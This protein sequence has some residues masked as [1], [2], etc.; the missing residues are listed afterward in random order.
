MASPLALPIGETAALDALRLDA[1]PLHGGD[2]DYDALVERVG[3]AT[4]VLLGEASHG[5]HEFYRERARITR[6]LIEELGFT[7]VA[8]EGDWP[9][10][11]RVSR[12]VQGAGDDADAEE[13][14]RGFQRF[15]TW[16]WRNAEV[17][18]FVG[19]LR[20][21]NEQVAP[22]RRSVGF[23]GLDL[24]SLGASMEAVVAYLEEVDPPAAARARSRYECLHP[25]SGDSAGYGQA[26]LLGVSEPCRR[27][28]LEQLIELRRHAGDY[29]HEDGLVAEDRYFLAEQNA[30][31][32]RNAE[33]YYRTMFGGPA[34]S[35]NLR[36]RHMADTLDQLQVHL[37][38]HGDA[39]KVVVWEHNSHVGDARSTEMAQRGEL[40]LGQLMR[41]RHARDV[42]LVGF[43]TYAGTVT[44]ASEWGAEAERKRVRPGLPDS[45][46]ALLHAT[47]IPAFLLCPLGMSASGRALREPRLQ[48]AIGVI[49]RPES[50]RQSH[51]FLACAS[52]QF[53]AL[54]HID[55][56]RA[57][58]PLERTGSW[59]LGEP[60]E[61][62]PSAL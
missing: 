10:A 17:L 27:R 7:A 32:V 39:G 8:V 4:L 51:W 31:V 25:F 22:A 2:A 23:Y 13:A 14:L 11:Y 47:E 6:R 57:V 59:E 16:M 29:L 26:V 43:S 38:R 58:E 41:E 55:L 52:Q 37:A 62:Y 1:Q 36:D 24:Y 50:E 21:H 42:V 9:D 61:T 53:D 34:P 54:V 45:Y 60:P 56:T 46:E 30:T 44:A 28:V 48:R 3:D 5:T 40:N 18:D 33:E 12:Y 19:W 49:Y 35:W 20:A 15:P